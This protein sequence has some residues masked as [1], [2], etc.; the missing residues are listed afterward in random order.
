MSVQD[1][2]SRRL[3]TV[4]DLRDWFRSSVHEAMVRNSVEATESTGDYVVNVLTE[5]SRS[6][7]LYRMTEE[8]G[9][10]HQPLAMIYRDAVESSS[11]EVRRRNL[12]R[13]GDLALFVAGFFA[14][15]LQRKLVDVDYYAGMGGAAYS[16]L[17]EAPPRSFEMLES[18][19]VFGELA[20][21]FTDFLDVLAEVAE[22]ARGNS[23]QNVMR[24]YELWLRTGSPRARR[25]LEE[26]G[27]QPLQSSV[28]GR[29]H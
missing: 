22:T 16:S 8:E 17:A 13:L 27:I 12:Q 14:E 4:N 6:E 26:M 25:K 9:R 5:Y 7:N 3:M 21:K 10:S 28:I 20:E 2:D 15:S 23:E 29:E 1:H 24:L 18:N 19:A 11:E